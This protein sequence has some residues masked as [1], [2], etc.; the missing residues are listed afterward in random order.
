MGMLGADMLSTDVPEFKRV[1]RAMADVSKNLGPSWRRDRKAPE[2]SDPCLNT[3]AKEAARWKECRA[4]AG[5]G[6]RDERF[7]SSKNSRVK[8]SGMWLRA[9]CEQVKTSLVFLETEGRSGN[10]FRTRLCRAPNLPGTRVCALKLN[11]SSKQGA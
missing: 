4:G 8:D 3:E 1:L 2:R 10:Q 11:I 5:E 9:E 6:H 7:P